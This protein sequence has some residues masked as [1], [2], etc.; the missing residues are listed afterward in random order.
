VLED[1]VGTVDGVET[2]VDGRAVLP[3]LVETVGG[4]TRVVV[5]GPELVSIVDDTLY[6][7]VGASLVVQSVLV[8]GTSELVVA[9][10]RSVV[11]DSV[12]QDVPVVFAKFQVEKVTDL[13]NVDL[14]AL[15]E[16]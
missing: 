16:V 7:L 1:V 9:I 14:R 3:E 8:D 12:S 6:V 5:D 11:D 4:D 2:V 10:V 15:P 13:V